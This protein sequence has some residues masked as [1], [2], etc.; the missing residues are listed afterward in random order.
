MEPG[1]VTMAFP[2]PG[3]ALK[4]LLFLIGALGILEAIVVNYVP[5]GARWFSALACSTEGVLH[6]QVFPG[7]PEVWRLVTAGFLTRPDTLGHLIF[8]LIGLYF[9]SPDLEKRWG[10]ARFVRFILASF[11]IGFLLSIAVDIVASPNAPAAFHPPFMY[12]ATAAITA[13]SIAWSKINA[14]LQVRL[15]FFLPVS[16]RQLFWVTIGFCVLGLIYPAS[17]PEGVA[18]PFGGVLTGLLLGGSP[19]VLRTLWLRLKLVVL[20][21]R[22]ASDAAALSS[23]PA[24]RKKAGADSPP[25]RIVQGGLED[26]LKKRRPP[27]DKRYLN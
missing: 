26:E 19:S 25:L 5:D 8:T 10:S 3:P 12:G 2:R 21:Q 22:G 17:I 15:F 14:H 13:T 24:P 11:V 6:G 7:V 23:R 27:K 18:A 4:T 1:Q 20:R 9:L 16:G